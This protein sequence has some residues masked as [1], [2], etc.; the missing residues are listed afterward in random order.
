[1]ELLEQHY[2]V[3]HRARMM[4]EEKKVASLFFVDIDDDSSYIYVAQTLF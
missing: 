3:N 2:D 4:V 1:M